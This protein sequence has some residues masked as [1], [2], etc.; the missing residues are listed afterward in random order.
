MLATDYLDY[1]QIAFLL[2]DQPSELVYFIVGLVN[3]D[4]LR[5]NVRGDEI[6]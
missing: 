2:N 3:I 4:L 1:F 5:V 6:L